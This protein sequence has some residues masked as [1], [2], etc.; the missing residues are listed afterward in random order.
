MITTAVFYKHIFVFVTVKSQ[1]K[2]TNILYNCWWFQEEHCT[3][4]VSTKGTNT[5]FITILEL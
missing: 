1:S 3:Y 2:C 5:P 4:L